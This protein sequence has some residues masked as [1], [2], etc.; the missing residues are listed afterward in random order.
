MLRSFLVVLF[1]GLLINT[2]LFSQN[3]QNITGFSKLGDFDGHSYFLS[4]NYL[5]W[6]D[7]HQFAQQAGGYLAAMNTSEENEFV[8][9]HLGNNMV[10]IG[11]NDKDQE[12]SFQWTNGEPMTINLSTNNSEI[13]DFAVMN[14]WNGHWEMG[15]QWQ[16]RRFV[17]EIDGTSTTTPTNPDPVKVFIFAGQSNMSGGGVTNELNPSLTIVP[18]NATLSIHFYG[19]DYSD[20]S[21]G[22]FGPEVEFIQEICHQNPSQ[23][24]LFIKYAWGGTGLSEWMPGSYHYQTLKNKVYQ[25]LGTLNADYELAGFLW[26]QGETDAFNAD[27]A[28]WY[29]QRLQTMISTLRNELGEPNLPVLIGQVDPPNA[30]CSAIVQAAEAD[31]VANDGHARMVL[32]GGL[33]RLWSDPIHYNTAGQIDFGHRFLAAYQTLAPKGFEFHCPANIVKVLGSGEINETITWDL[34]DFESS[35]DMGDD[36][37]V[38]Q[39]QGKASG[40][41][42]EVGSYTVAYAANDD[43]QNKDTC[44][45]SIKVKAFTACPSQVE[46]FSKLGTFNGHTYF[47]SEKNRTWEDAQNFSEEHGGYLATMTTTEENDFLKGKLGNHMVFIGLSD[48][49]NEGQLQWANGESLSLD[50]SFGNSGDKDFAVMN[51]WAGTWEMVNKKVEKPYVMEMDCENTYATSSNWSSLYMMSPVYPNPAN[52]VISFDF[53]VATDKETMFR[54]FSESGYLFLAEKRFLPKGLS[55]V[56]IDIGDLPKGR[57]TI[58]ANQ[59]QQSFKFTKF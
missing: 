7:A 44:Q 5:T 23:K 15:N 16:Q 21:A 25:A 29:G 24:Y 53:D 12:G 3:S 20:F 40:S 9:K 26:M 8:R 55:K 52:A 11:L 59:N 31:F 19:Y 17:L 32:T 10:F 54:I 41:T 4:E 22:N 6:A 2:P 1:L 28:G 18:P 50:L 56:S 35:C 45:F 46:G 47:L 37:H 33:S 34:D 58:R 39:I 27:D 57:Y 49:D 48:K 36:V 30:C 14:F 13:N 43:C 51:F 38:T 42:F